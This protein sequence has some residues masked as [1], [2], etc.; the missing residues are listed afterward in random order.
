MTLKRAVYCFFL[1]YTDSGDNNYNKKCT[2]CVLHEA[3]VGPTLIDTFTVYVTRK[4]DQ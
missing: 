4:T 2:M 1:P 3:S